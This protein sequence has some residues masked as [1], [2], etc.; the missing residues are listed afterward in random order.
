MAR[1]KNDE[2]DAQKRSVFVLMKNHGLTKHGRTHHF[3][4]AGTEFNPESDKE[5]ISALAQSGALIE[6]K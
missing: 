1:T 3:Y 6:L 2:V 5:T 4:E